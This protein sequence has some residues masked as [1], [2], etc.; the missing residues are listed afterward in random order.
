M[1][2][3]THQQNQPKDLWL[4]ADVPLS[5]IPTPPNLADPKS[6]SSLCPS[7]VL[8][9]FGGLIIRDHHNLILPPMLQIGHLDPLKVAFDFLEIHKCILYIMAL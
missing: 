1:I 6:K 9:K 2:L 3:Q 7:G 4:I 5:K 8:L